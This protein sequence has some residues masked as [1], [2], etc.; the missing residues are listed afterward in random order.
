MGDVNKY[1]QERLKNAE[2]KE[3]TQLGR[4]CDGNDHAWRPDTFFTET[5]GE[6]DAP[7]W[8]VRP[9]ELFANPQICMKIAAATFEKKEQ[10][11][12]EKKQQKK[13]GKEKEK[14]KKKTAKAKDKKK[15]KAKKKSKKEKD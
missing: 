4:F 2:T 1:E 11:R 15:K 14:K 7:P 12:K 6:A 5:C 3:D 9:S 10:L 8:P 13:G